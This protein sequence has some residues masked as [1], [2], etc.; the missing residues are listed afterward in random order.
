[1]TGLMLAAGQGN[2]EAARDARKI[3]LK[4][5]GA[6]DPATVNKRGMSA[7]EIKRSMMGLT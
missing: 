2:K 3:W 6:A 1:M 5:T 7:E 4:L